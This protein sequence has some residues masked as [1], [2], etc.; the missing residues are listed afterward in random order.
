MCCF[1]DLLQGENFAQIDVDPYHAMA[2]LK[3]KRL[4]TI[5]WIPFS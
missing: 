5:A 2:A 1:Q 4:L 3:I